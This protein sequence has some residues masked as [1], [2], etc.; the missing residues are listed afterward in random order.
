MTHNTVPYL[1][2][3]NHDDLGSMIFHHLYLGYLVFVHLSLQLNRHDSGLL[4]LPQSV[5]PRKQK[6]LK[7]VCLTPV[8][9]KTDAC[10]HREE[11]NVVEN[12]SK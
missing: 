12:T 9:N 5:L 10:K 3:N 1:T 7:Q 4:Q 2:K 11:H 6:L 8:N